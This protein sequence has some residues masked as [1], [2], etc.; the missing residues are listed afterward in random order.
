MTMVTM[1]LVAALNQGYWFGG[2]TGQIT[3]RWT[4]DQPVPDTVLIWNLDLKVGAV[5]LADGRV[6][7]NGDGTESRI[8]MTMPTVRMRAEAVFTWRVVEPESGT[9][10]QQGKLSVHLFPKDLLANSKKLLVEHKL[11]VW[12]APEG[13]PAVL[14]EAEIEHVR[15]E[16]ATGLQFTDADVILVGVDQ[17]ADDAFDQAA[18]L[19]LARSGRSV[20]IFAQKRPAKLMGYPLAKRSS[21]GQVR[22]RRTHPLLLDLDGQDVA[23]WL[24]PRS[25]VSALR[26]PADAPVHE[27]AFWQ[28]HAPGPQAEPVPIDALL[29]VKSVGS[30]RLVFCQLPLGSWTDDPR[31][32]LVLRNA[33]EYLLTPPQPTLRPSARRRPAEP[34]RT[35]Q[36]TI[37]ISPGVEQ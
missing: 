11:L 24:M 29:A 23:S 19:A 4:F 10:L 26:L 1:L 28:R 25:I 3:A 36:S 2:A 31:S 7:L 21:S 5:R 13:I 14:D 22:W 9:L 15:I 12:D 32:Q 35:D 34:I 8:E 20:M 37:T 27:I 6:K 33:L 17:I 18:L 30:G 16:D